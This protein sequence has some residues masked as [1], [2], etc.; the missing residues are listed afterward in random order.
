MIFFADPFTLLLG[1]LLSAIIGGALGAQRRRRSM[2]MCLGFLFGPLGWILVLLMQPEGEKC[3]A[4]K[5]V[6]EPGATACRH[7]GRDVIQRVGFRPYEPM[8]DK[9]AAV[10]PAPPVRQRTR[11]MKQ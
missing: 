3:H 10:K 6:L 4:C 5:G 11:K 9:D 1:L 7:C 2:G 8:P